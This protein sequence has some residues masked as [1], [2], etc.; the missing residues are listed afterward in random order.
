[1]REALEEWDSGISIGRR[2][3]TNLIYANDTTLLAKLICKCIYPYLGHVELQGVNFYALKLEIT[4]R[5]IYQHANVP[6]LTTWLMTSNCVLSY[7]NTM[8]LVLNHNMT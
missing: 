4:S 1:M 5:P 3:V 6:L 8:S 2:M 7:G